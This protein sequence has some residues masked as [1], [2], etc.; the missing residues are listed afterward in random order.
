[1]RKYLFR[2]AVFGIAGAIDRAFVAG[3]VTPR[4]HA[5]K[6]STEALGPQERL[7]GLS[8]VEAFYG[9]PTWLEPDSGFF[10]QSAPI[11]PRVQRARRLGSSG[12][13]LDLTWESEF[14]TL[15]TTDRVRARL[16][17]AR[18]PTAL[19][20]AAIDETIEG[21]ERV[22]GTHG[23]FD[24]RYRAIGGNRVA[25]ARHYRHLTGPRPAVVL[26]HGFMGGFLP[27]EAHVLQAERFYRG[28]M[29]VILTV[30]PLHG[31]RRERGRGLVPPRFPGAD[32]RFTVEGFRQLV[33]D[34]EALFDYLL[35]GRVLS[36]G[37]GGM[38]LGAYSS[39]LLATLDARLT[40]ALFQMPLACIADFAQSS[41]RLVGTTEDQAAQAAAL[42][43]VQHPISPLARRSRL[44]AERVH[45]VSGA[46]DHVTG[47]EQ[48]RL[49]AEHFGATNT[50]FAGGH[51][52]QFERHRALRPFFDMIAQAGLW[53]GKGAN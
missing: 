4:R 51:L 49:L 37:I 12:E 43:R 5:R 10:P 44:P 6:N 26:L 7:Q 31:P 1:M 52:F 40:F 18:H 50:S 38:S 36:L 45:V 34:H 42:K 33:F 29:D 14:H 30:L 16:S 24:S 22:A 3:A 28:G 47:P 39:A 46:A 19:S 53:S 20:D 32:P 15:W 9:D 21:L 13:V 17:G 25:Y 35:D 23:E 11:V 48:A 27:L 8:I 2:R 41:G